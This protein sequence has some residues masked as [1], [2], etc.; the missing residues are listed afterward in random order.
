MHYKVFHP[1][2]IVNCEIDLPA[3]KSISNR[4]LIIQA[5]CQQDF[6]IKNLSNSDDTN[7]LK[8]ALSGTQN[9]IDIGAAGTSF[10]FLTSYLTIQKGRE[11]ILTGTDRMKER[12]IQNLVTTLQL[13]GAKISYLEKDGL[14]PLKIKGVTILGREIT[15]DASISSQFI[16][17][18]LL[19]APTLVNGLILNISGNLVS[20]SYIQMTLKLM[21]EFG[22]NHSWDKNKIVVKQQHY[23]GKNYNVEADW[24]AATF[25]F[26]IAALTKGCNIQ[27]KGLYQESIQGDAKVRTIFND[28]GIVSIFE[29]NTL[30]LT[31]NNK[32][33]FP[34]AVNLIDSP[35]MYQSLRC[36]L[37]ALNKTAELTGIST[38][39][40]KETDRKKA[41]ENELKK[42]STSKIIETY[43]D[44]RMAM[45]F[46][47]LSLK[48]G[49]ITIKNSDVVSKSYP[50]FWQDL[51]NAGFIIS[52]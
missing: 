12:P 22:V 38:L 6:E 15:I 51:S 7:S 14:P 8:N 52:P 31:K 37:F 25:W 5:L 29:N 50:N 9:T 41:V 20:K 4:L 3:S 32:Q 21:E 17:S 43:K 18:L 23:I 10:R 1:T 34:E 2:K 40:N 13:L 11:C 49:E 27:L 44:H 30:I 16:S 36:T 24:S 35:D 46:A 48:Y 28:F 42:L 45:S 26:Q 47:P 19:I 33:N 39:K